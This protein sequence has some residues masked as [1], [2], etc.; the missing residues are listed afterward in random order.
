MDINNYDKLLK[1]AMKI[2]P[3]NVFAHSRFTIPS[4]LIYNEGNKTIISNFKEISD[5][6]RREHEYILKYLSLWEKNGFILLKNLSLLQ[7]YRTENS[8]EKL[9]T[10]FNQVTEHV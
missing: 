5:R 4:V 6:L 2:I 1:R 9:A 10:L 3:K 7:K 8:V